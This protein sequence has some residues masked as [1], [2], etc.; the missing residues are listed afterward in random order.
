MTQPATRPR[1]DIVMTSLC[2]FQRCHRYVSNETTNDVSVERRQDI[3]VVRLYD[4]F[5]ERRNDALKRRNNDVPLLRLHDVSSKSQMKHPTTSQWHVTKTSQWYVSTTS[6][7]YVST[8]SPVSPK[9]NTQQRCCGTSPS[10]VGV[11]L[12]WRSLRF[13]VTLSWGQTGRF[14]RLKLVEHFLHL[15]T[16]TYI[17]N[18][19]SIDLV[20]GAYIY[21]F[22]SKLIYSLTKKS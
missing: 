5:L 20:A 15:K 1:S 6:N 17:N 2:T 4:T 16:V 8:T 21:A 9:W 22:L 7:Y 13:Q 11:T 19:C 18:I 10:H 14:P 3:L 12:L